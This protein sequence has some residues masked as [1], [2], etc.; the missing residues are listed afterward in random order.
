MKLLQ[1]TSHFNGHSILY[2]QKESKN[3][4]KNLRARTSTLASVSESGKRE[5]QAEF[6][7]ENTNNDKKKLSSFSLK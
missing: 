6:T 2:H 1:K 7:L 4:V 3:S 5:K